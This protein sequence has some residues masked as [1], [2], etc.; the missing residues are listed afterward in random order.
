MCVSC[1]TKYSFDKW[2]GV[3]YLKK[4]FDLAKYL[5]LLFYLCEVLW[6]KMEICFKKEKK[7]YFKN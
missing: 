6:K 4:K 5:F 7:T 2:I 1:A 3:F